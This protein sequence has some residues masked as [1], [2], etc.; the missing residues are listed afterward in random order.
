MQ[1]TNLVSN[2]YYPM[3]KVCL[4]SISRCNFVD[5]IFLLDSGSVDE[6]VDFHK[7]IPKVKFY[8]F[9]KW[10]NLDGKIG[11]NEWWNGQNR[12]AVELSKRAT[13]GQNLI[14][15]TCQIDDFWPV[16]FS[17]E[18][19]KAIAYLISEKKDGFTFPWTKVYTK[20]V[21]EQTGA[22]Y[23]HDMMPIR[24]MGIFRMCLEENLFWTGWLPSQTGI[25]I[26]GSKKDFD[27]LPVLFKNTAYQYD[28]WFF[29]REH[30][31]NKLKNHCEWGPHNLK[32][33]L[34]AF[35]KKMSSKAK[36][37]NAEIVKVTSH[38]PEIQELIESKLTEDHLGWSFF[39]VLAG[40]DNT[41]ME[42]K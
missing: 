36:L 26:S 35:H 33:P 25:L 23:Q 4:E 19:E 1:A 21:T 6:T 12:I 39:G 11:L 22:R 40:E 10:E 14:M 7:D 37:Y 20:N 38:P 27:I 18:M 9:D 32:S 41:K 30:F 13:S 15:I 16:K 3:S 17:V 28:N 8:S 2:G 42:T 31:D 5:E 24:H 34:E 29:T